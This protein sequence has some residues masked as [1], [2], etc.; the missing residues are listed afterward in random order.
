MSSKA[1]QV[2]SMSTDEVRNIAV[3]MGAMMN[4]G[5]TI[6]G[7]PTIEGKAALTITNAQSN[8]SALTINRRTVAVGEAA[9]FTAACVV[10]GTY[11]ID[12]LCSTTESQTIE[13]KIT[14]VVEETAN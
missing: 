14:L 4:S 1:P 13:G 7:T 5:E 10:A 8:S 6:S 12:I 2:H 9:Q 11:I 3:D